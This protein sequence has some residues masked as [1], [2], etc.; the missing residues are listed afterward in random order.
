M[1]ENDDQP[2]LY[3]KAR[4]PD[5][6][7]SAAEA[8]LLSEGASSAFRRRPTPV[9]TTPPSDPRQP[10]QPPPALRTSFA[11]PPSAGSFAPAQHFYGPAGGDHYPS[12]SRRRKKKKRAS[13][14]SEWPLPEPDTMQNEKSVERV[15]L[16]KGASWGCVVATISIMM[17]AVALFSL[18]DSAVAWASL[19]V[20]WAYSGVVMMLLVPRRKAFDCELLLLVWTTWLAYGELLRDSEW[21]FS[22][23]SAILP[24][25]AI[26][27]LVA[28]SYSKRVEQDTRML[29]AVVFAF[30]FLL[31]FP[32]RGALSFLIST[33]FIV[34]HTFLF[35]IVFLAQDYVIIRRYG[36]QPTLRERAYLFHVSLKIIRSVWVLLVQRL[37]LLLLIVQLIYF[38]RTVMRIER[39][40]VGRKKVEP[41]LP[42]SSSSGGVA[43][44]MPNSFAVPPSFSSGASVPLASHRPPPPFQQQ[45]QQQQQ[46]H[47]QPPQPQP[48]QQFPVQQQPPNQFTQ[49]ARTLPLQ[50]PTAYAAEPASELVGV[51]LVDNNESR[52]GSSSTSNSTGFASTSAPLAGAFRGR[53]L[54]RSAPSAASVLRSVTSAGSPFLAN[55][56]GPQ[57]WNTNP[58]QHLMN[59]GYLQAASTTASATDQPVFGSSSSTTVAAA[60]SLGNAAQRPPAV[61]Q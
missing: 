39:T 4:R 54:P 25:L 60:D 49:T 52:L 23:G 56:A 34:L 51:S 13:V 53:P 38:V 57:R 1:F 35:A 27:T 42:V 11:S 14:L 9:L 31:L 40:G 50:Q 10:L 3:S 48:Y 2:L 28:A 59:T 46:Q 36:G 22:G 21:V 55:P 47:Q 24:T 15:D 32:Q 6:A 16:S 45:Q 44:N 58:V 26:L 43:F 37:A 19:A 30:F 61:Q 17:A 5:T 12:S 20:F 7:I 8:I 41:I 29:S 18:H 33:G